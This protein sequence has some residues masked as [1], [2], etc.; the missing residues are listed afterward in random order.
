MKAEWQDEL[1]EVKQGHC[2]QVTAMRSKYQR[3]IT[4]LQRL[5]SAQIKLLKSDLQ[6]LRVFIVKQA[7]QRPKA[8]IMQPLVEQ[9]VRQN[10]NHN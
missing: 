10:Q 7:D 3:I 8:E 4:Q 6:S 5:S 1:F 2:E 9:I